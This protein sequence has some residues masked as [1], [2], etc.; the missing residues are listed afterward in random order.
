MFVGGKTAML[1]DA[2]HVVPVLRRT[3]STDARAAAEDEEPWGLDAAYRNGGHP[4]GDG[5]PLPF[6][7]LRLGERAMGELSAFHA[8]GATTGDDAPDDAFGAFEVE[9]HAFRTHR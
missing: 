5:H 4:E 1:V 3:T 8:D 9:T 6:H 2:D 7:P